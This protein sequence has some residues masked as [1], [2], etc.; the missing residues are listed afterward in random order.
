MK[1][2]RK[3]NE[4]LKTINSMHH[5]E[6]FVLKASNEVDKKYGTECYL[7]IYYADIKN[8]SNTNISITAV[9]A[10]GNVMIDREKDKPA[11]IN[12]ILSKFDS[13]FAKKLLPSI[14]QEPI[15][16]GLSFDMSELQKD[17]TKVIESGGLKPENV[18]VMVKKSVGRPR[19]EKVD[20]IEST[21][22]LAK[23]SVGRPRKEKVTTPKVEELEEEFII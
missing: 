17:A 23:K 4:L 13:D 9:D 21:V 16:K 22:A 8:T 14:D 6:R 20:P 2:P 7:E 18:E 10:E 11:R 15:P 3:V 12:R 1:N 19:K 5:R